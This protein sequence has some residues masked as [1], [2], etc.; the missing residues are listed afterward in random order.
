MIVSIINNICL[1]KTPH[2]KKGVKK[3]EKPSKAMDMI[4]V[5]KK[6]WIILCKNKRS[7]FHKLRLRSV[8]NNNKTLSQPALISAVAMPFAEKCGNRIIAS[9]LFKRTEIIAKIIG[10]LVSSWAKK[11]GTKLFMS[12]KAGNPKP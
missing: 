11:I 8:K 4:K 10:V 9:M 3:Y 7:F 1:N 5:A 2:I 6:I 12:T